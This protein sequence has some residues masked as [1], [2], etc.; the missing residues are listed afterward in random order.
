MTALYVRNM[1]RDWAAAVAEA[2]FYDTVN[3]DQNP[4]EPIWFTVQFFGQSNEG[5]TFCGDGYIERGAFDVVFNAP[6]GTGDVPV[7]TVMEPAVAALL[8]NLDPAHKLT[9]QSYD[10]IEE[11]S[12]GSADKTYRMVIGV[13][14][15]YSA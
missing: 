9:I 15:S 8:A 3:I 2:P 14:Y 11:M 12:A 13:N 6:P 1:V 5:G 10:P 7:L 4:A